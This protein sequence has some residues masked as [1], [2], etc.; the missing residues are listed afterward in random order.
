[1]KIYDKLVRDRIPEIISETGSIPI[2]HIADDDEY[3][4]KLKE[5]LQEEVREFL[6]GSNFEEELADILEV[7]E[8]ICEVKGIDSTQLRQTQAKKAL[9]RGGFK[10]RIILE[11][12][13]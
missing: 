7:I 11:Q 10:K 1:M 2:T 3:W 6:D 13:N 8:A 12:T 5:K 4:E 9:A